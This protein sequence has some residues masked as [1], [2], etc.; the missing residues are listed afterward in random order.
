M[1][2]YTECFSLLLLNKN[3]ISILMCRIN[4]LRVA[5]QIC[6]CYIHSECKYLNYMK[7]YNYDFNM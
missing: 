4:C 1:Q 6:T 7:L 3:S 5:V 2:F